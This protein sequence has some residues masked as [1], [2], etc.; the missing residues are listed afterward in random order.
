MVLDRL[1]LVIAIAAAFWCAVWLVRLFVRARSRH[2]LQGDSRSLWSALGANP[3]GRTTIVSF[4]SPSCAACR[5][6]QTPAIGAAARLVGSDAVRV[7]GVDVAAQ[8]EVA[9]AFGVLTVP[10]TVILAAD[11]RLAAI[12]QGFVPTDRLTRQLRGA[13]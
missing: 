10:S 6:A 1:F 11:G 4:S 8:P 2:L 3:D 9:R 7:V 12:N 5:T 13:V